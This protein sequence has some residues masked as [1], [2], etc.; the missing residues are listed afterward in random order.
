M[1]RGQRPVDCLVLSG[2]KATALLSI[3]ASQDG[4]D[5][6]MWITDPAK[7]APYVTSLRHDG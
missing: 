6:L 1:G 7:A 4:I 2:G 3:E 5:H